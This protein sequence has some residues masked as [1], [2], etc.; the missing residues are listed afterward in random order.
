MVDNVLARL[1]LSPIALLYGAGVGLRNFLYQKGLLKSVR[2][3]LPLIS[4]GNLTVGGAGK[5]PHIEYLLVLLKDYIRVA[6]LSRGYGRQTKG[7]LEVLPGM[8]A[9]QTGDEPLQFKRKFRDVVVAV[10]ESRTFA[11]PQILSSH[12][13]TQLILLDDAFQHRAIAPGMHILLTE[14]SEPFIRDWLLPSGRLREWRSAYRRAHLIVVTKCPIDLSPE[15]ARQVETEIKPLDHQQVFFSYYE[16]GAPYSM[17]NPL[18][19]L[20]LQPGLHVLLVT[21]IARTDYLVSY[22]EERVGGLTHMEYADH[23]TF[24][25]TDVRNIAKAF[26][27]LEAGQKEKV[28]I[29]TEKDAVRLEPFRMILLEARIPVAVLPIQVR[30]HFDQGPVFDEAIRSFLLNFE[31]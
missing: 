29:T 3:D 1:L 11:I 16:Y 15:E 30:F 8:Q 13:D 23:H 10:A 19:R 7:Y 25:D 20:K 17:Y 22:L 4:V 9:R 28:L 24:D 21:A 31:V 5:T 14:Y 26:Q 2:F 12:P 6:T 27:R 18:R